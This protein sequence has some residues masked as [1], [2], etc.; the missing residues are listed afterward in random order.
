MGRGAG[1]AGAGLAWAGA[2]GGPRGLQYLDPFMGVA[3]VAGGAMKQAMPSSFARQG[4]GRGLLGMAQQGHAGLGGV[5]SRGLGAGAAAAGGY[6]AVGAAGSWALD[7]MHTGAQQNF[8]MSGVLSAANRTNMPNMFMGT[9]GMGSA[10]NV[11]DI[12]GMVRQMA[13]QKDALGMF[14]RDF[15]SLAATMG[16]GIQSGYF[17][18]TNTVQQ[19]KARFR[20]L[21][22]STE[23]LATALK[24]SQQEAL[25]FMQQQRGLGFTDMRQAAAGA[26]FSAQMAA[27]A[28]V[29]PGEMAGIG[30]QGAQISRRFG[31]RGA[32]GALMGQQTAAAIGAARQGGVMSEAQL[33]DI[34]GGLG[35][36]Q[37]IGALSGAWQS[38]A[39]GVMRGRYGKRLL[40]A[41]MDPETGGI[42]PM[43]TQAFA[44]GMMGR[45]DLMQAYRKNIRSR[46]VRYA[47]RA[48]GESLGAEAVSQIGPMGVLSGVAGMEFEKHPR[49][50]MPDVQRII[51]QKI[52]GLGERQSEAL[53]DVISRLPSLKG[54]IQSR[55]S[56][57][58]D[59]GISAQFQ[60]EGLWQ[61]IK[62]EIY[63]KTVGRIEEGLKNLGGRMQTS[64][65]DW[66]TETVQ[67]W[68]GVRPTF[69][70]PQHRAAMQRAFYGD[71]GGAREMMGGPMSATGSPGGGGGFNAYGTMGWPTA[72]GAP[73]PGG[74]MAGL[75]GT[76]GMLSESRTPLGAGSIMTGG[77]MMQAAGGAAFAGG[78]AAAA[79]GR[80]RGIAGAAARLG[81]RAVQGAGGIG[82]GAGWLGRGGM[83]GGAARAAGPAGLLLAGADIYDSALQPQYIGDP[84]SWLGTRTPFGPRLSEEQSDIWGEM[85]A[86]GMVDPAA[87]RP[88]IGGR[89]N[90]EA[91]ETISTGGRPQWI[92]RG[93]IQGQE[94]GDWVQVPMQTG[95]MA[96]F[97][98]RRIHTGGFAGAARGFW[99]VRSGEMQRVTEM[100]AMSSIAPQE[101]G[102]QY[103]G[104]EPGEESALQRVGNE[105]SL[106]IARDIESM[107]TADPEEEPEEYARQQIRAYAAVG[108]KIQ[109]WLGD[110]PL[111]R[112]VGERA[113]G[114]GGGGPAGLGG[115]VAVA[116]GGKY[117]YD[118][119]TLR[120]VNAGRLPPKQLTRQQVEE[121]LQGSLRFGLGLGAFGPAMGGIARGMRKVPGGK[122]QLVAFGESGVEQGAGGAQVGRMGGVLRDV[123]M[124]A[125]GVGYG[126]A[127][128]ALRGLWG[129]ASSG[130]GLGDARERLRK[131]GKKMLGGATSDDRGIRELAGWLGG[132]SEMSPEEL[133]GLF[134]GPGQLGVMMNEVSVQQSQEA[135]VRLK[136]LANRTRTHMVRDPRG[137]RLSKMLTSLGGPRATEELNRYIS[138][139]ERGGEQGMEQMGSAMERF[140]DIM[141]DRIKSPEDAA[142]LNQLFSGLPAGQELATATIRRAQIEQTLRDPRLKKDP[143][144]VLGLLSGTWV[145]EDLIRQS[146]QAKGPMPE[147][148]IVLSKI[149]AS[150][151]EREPVAGS[152]PEGEVESV[153]RLIHKQYYGKEL[154]DHE[155]ERVA[156]F[157]SKTGLAPDVTGQRVA[158]PEV[159]GKVAE[160]FE[161]MLPA[162]NKAIDKLAKIN[163]T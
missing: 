118:N 29:T 149:E 159:L 136:Q 19:F 144:K 119:T 152:M 151:R 93:R 83:L 15:E 85:F 67:E 63:S 114:A 46:D 30:L 76:G 79:W 134:E 22:E 115:L 61:R 31:G 5:L 139:L 21:V 16:T 13:S 60:G 12:S 102:K 142:R 94:M 116:T 135:D 74:A 27:G 4:L 130:E 59:E 89:A 141:A 82:M 3:N 92:S 69:V 104:L 122:E 36:A 121:G 160:K 23:A 9:G 40:G 84:G 51:L 125:E 45:D 62:D 44:S 86:A 18:T 96:G 145:G 41:M 98:G 117:R 158:G 108:Q 150:L 97:G 2:L 109:G 163:K 161:A 6:M 48:R 128:Q 103:Y 11:G 123:V 99:H 107:I 42:D 133:A 57:A 162:L 71:I 24:S 100:V 131:A 65:T 47:M 106:E 112:K 91:G 73:M 54:D 95:G 25:Q 43:R 64:I 146:S 156:G 20:E 124:G 88:G 78:G 72:G 126:E 75:F 33:M 155:K 77:R 55:W 56:K 138:G 90:V 39:M 37:G 87:M 66:L 1:V 120:Q 80:G 127:R 105:H 111:G 50:H 101:M 129:A 8:M 38:Q 52:T 148:G 26:A 49:G 137:R 70:G 14:S 68:S 34:T 143:K 32:A 140:S 132:V 53:R 28:G 10:Q 110:T 113:G 153:A 58:L 35:G 154:Q 17:K 81:G 157:M 7:Q 147:E